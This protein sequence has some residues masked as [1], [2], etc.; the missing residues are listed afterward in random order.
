MRF[1]LD[2]QRRCDDPD[3]P[4]AEAFERWLLLAAIAERKTGTRLALAVVGEEEGRRLHA[5]YLVEARATNVLAFPP[6]SPGPAGFLGDL[7]LCAP[8][9]R[10][11]A[12]VQGKSLE[13]HYAHLTLH[14]F[15]HL[16]G[17]LHARPTERRRMERR[18]RAL[19]AALGYPDP[20]RSRARSGRG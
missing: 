20:Y 5:R 3:V 1:G 15:L 6:A 13:A 14:G 11:E 12:R 18:E 8:V 17:Y 10:R 4:G 19:L 9:V 16:L 2:F 7:V